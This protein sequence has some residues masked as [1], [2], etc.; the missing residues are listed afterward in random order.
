MLPDV[1]FHVKLPSVKESDHYQAHPREEIMKPAHIFRD[2]VNVVNGWFS[3][4]NDIEQ[5]IA[6]YFLLRRLGP[7]QAR[8]L[9][10]VLDHTFK[11]SANDVQMLEQEANNKEFLM[12]L[13]KENKDF[14]VQSLLMHLP[15]LHP[16]NNEAKEQYLTLLPH[17]L[18]HSLE[19][20]VHE[21]EC[22]QLFSL[23]VVHPAF[24]HQEK[25]KL[26]HWL[27]HLTEKEE[28]SKEKRHNLA[29]HHTLSDSSAHYNKGG[30]DSWRIQASNHILHGGQTNGWRPQTQA[31]TQPQQQQVPQMRKRLDHKDSGIS[32]SFDELGSP[33]SGDI[34]LLDSYDDIGHVQTRV[35]RSSSF[36]VDPKNLH[37]KVSPQ[38]SL[39]SD[40]EFL[41]RRFGS[42]DETILAQPGMKDVHGWLKSLRLHKYSNIFSEMTYEEMLGLSD[43]FLKGKGVTVGA[44][45]KILV[46][47]QK[48]KERPQLL[49]TLEKEVLQMGKLPSVLAELKQIVITPIKPHVCSPPVSQSETADTVN[50][51]VGVIGDPP[52]PDDLPSQIVK[53]MGKACTQILVAQQDEEY[54][55]T[56]L[57]IVEKILANEAFTPPQ[58]RKLQSWKIQC[59]NMAKQLVTNRKVANTEKSLRSWM[60]DP[61]GPNMGKRRS[62]R[63]GSLKG[64]SSTGL[65]IAR[66]GPLANFHKRLGP[67]ASVSFNNPIKSHQSVCRTK[68]A[69]IRPSHIGQALHPDVTEDGPNKSFENLETLCRSMTEHALEDSVEKSSDQF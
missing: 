18:S 16:G 30:Q 11:D 45:N 60:M 12:S 14:A 19:K 50:A 21:E 43:D 13:Y 52:D 41:S 69:P 38:Q 35:T 23:A 5:T 24:T 57:W 33:A 56:Y 17:I 25:G 68:S 51:S 3:N 31:Q 64:T 20:S 49:A 40:D 47:L 32:T 15:L 28:K 63:G 9:S 37:K 44:T 62:P 58:K 2:Q 34:G 29:L 39:D 61:I 26:N 1:Y 27:S 66:A 8:F 22:R 55:L 6:C 48:L 59:K 4:W 36:P 7:T 65:G 67:S 46:C 42:P 53:V 54:C 10:L